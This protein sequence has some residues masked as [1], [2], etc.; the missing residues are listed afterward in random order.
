MSFNPPKSENGGLI[1][2]KP[3]AC[4]PG[5]P[6]W[7]F[8]Q[9]FIHVYCCFCAFPGF[10]V[11]S[12]LFVRVYDVS[13]CVILAVDVLCWFLLVFAGTFCVFMTVWVDSR[14]IM[15]NCRPA[16]CYVPR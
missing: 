13:K 11:C 1:S 14:E 10:S 2:L 3:S 15:M 4:T 16:C 9:A 12:Q 8:S 7:V 6:L 5:G